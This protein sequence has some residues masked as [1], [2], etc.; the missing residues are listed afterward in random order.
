MY[1]PIQPFRICPYS[2]RK[3]YCLAPELRIGSVSASTSDLLYNCEENHLTSVL[4]T[5][6]SWKMGVILNLYCKG[7]RGFS[8]QGLESIWRSD[9]VEDAMELQCS[10]QPWG[11]VF[12]VLPYHLCRASRKFGWIRREASPRTHPQYS[13]KGWCKL[14]MSKGSCLFGVSKGFLSPPEAGLVFFLN[15]VRKPLLC[16]AFREATF[17]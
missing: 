4:P 12:H 16:S 1:L 9:A 14:Q 15:P 2:K 13:G 8:N 11:H 10:R 5:F 17:E 7:M 6:S 3:E